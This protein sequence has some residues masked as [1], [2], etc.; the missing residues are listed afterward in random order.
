MVSFVQLPDFENFNDRKIVESTKIYDR[1][2]KILLYDVHEGIKRTMVP[3]EAIAPELKNATIAVEDANFYHHYGVE[4]KSILRAIIANISEGGFSQG[5][6]TITQQVVKNT[7]LTSDKNLTRKFKELLL[8][9]KLEQAFTKEEI[10]ELYL[11][12]IPYG[13]NIYGVAEAS[14]VFFGKE[15]RD[16]TLAQAA[17]IAALPKAPTFYSPYGNNRKNLDARKDF[18]LKR[19]R[20]LGFI[21]EVTYV[22]AQ[23]EKVEFLPREPRGIKAPHF[24]VW[25][26]E[27]LAEKYGEQALDEN[28]YR[29]I[30]TLDYEL[31]KKAEEIVSDHAA[32]ME[33]KFGAKNMAL[34]A[35][36]PKNGQVLAM[37][38]SRDYF[39][40]TNDGNF[41]V[42]L[43]Y[44]QPGSTFKPFAYATA[45]KK[46]YTP[47][48][49]LF[50]VPTNFSTDC[51]WHGV[52]LTPA[53]K[54]ED[55]YTPENYEGGYR[56]PISM[57][58]SLAQSRNITSVKTLYLAGL[59]DT[60]ATARRMGITSLNDE[61][62]F[63][64]SL[65]LGGGEVS[66]LDMTGAYGVFANDGVKNKT[67]A[68]LRIEDKAGKIIEEF[69]ES[70]EEVLPTE[71]A[72]QITSILSDNKAR[73]PTF[74]ANSALYFGGKDVAVKTGTTNNYKDV[75]TIGYTPK[76]VL[77]MWA[78]NNDATPIKKGN[79]AGFTVTL[80]WRAVM[81]DIL[82]KT[83]PEKFIP[84]E[85]E[86]L[87][88]LP[89]SLQGIWQGGEKYVVDT[90]SGKLAT[91][92]TPVQTKVIRVVPE[93]HT[94]LKWIK[95]DDPRGAPPTNPQNDAQFVLWEEPVRAWFAKQSFPEGDRS[96]IPTEYDNVH[97]PESSPIISLSGSDLAVPHTKADR[98]SITVGSTGPYPL[99]RVE[100]Y[101][102]GVFVDKS[103]QPPFTISFIPE[104]ID[105][106]N[107]ENE[108]TII[109]YDS[110][111]NKSTVSTKLKI[112]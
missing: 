91:P 3:F 45:F 19:M 98:I 66:L 108:I 4:P 58:S 18:V 10:L 30:T 88:A 33:T 99:S 1:T 25:I 86:D 87:T 81:D 27:Y 11:N 84:L 24:V 105:V 94:I 36:D 71:V 5:G 16:V 78:G 104:N 31:Q 59:K 34:V 90:I 93:V 6:S 2:G 14:R 103:T 79:S 112:Q 74:G 21:D 42:A 32:N 9:F 7:L 63:G 61:S 13:G 35:M 101:V 96:G 111:F 47:E 54:K 41:N 37:I 46:G 39:E 23:K 80:V 29:V 38:G 95:K 72:R 82:R 65:V 49:V 73:T 89:A 57:R 44:R 15:P 64:L 52:P 97:T 17:Y 26:K 28:G 92:N 56:G 76:I 48:T 60:I 69:Q 107:P 102:N 110:V 85:N 43:A 62:R 77:G 12:E 75:W 8:S 20:E 67:T 50:D 55:C 22:S 51:D 40:T 100:L 106:S 83:S 53:T 68:I 70:R 109:A